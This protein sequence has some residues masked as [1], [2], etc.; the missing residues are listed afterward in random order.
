MEDKLDVFNLRHVV[1]SEYWGSISLQ[2]VWS[3]FCFVSPT[4]ISILINKNEQQGCKKTCRLNMEGRER[5]N[6]SG[7]S[8][9]AR[10]IFFFFICDKEHLPS[11]SVWSRIV[12]LRGLSASVTPRTGGCCCGLPCRPAGCTGNGRSERCS[13]SSAVRSRTKA[14]TLSPPA[15]GCQRTGGPAC[16][17]AASSSACWRRT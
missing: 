9:S 12:L 7:T 10:L 17:W 2:N 5:G 14:P 11:V 15:L 8:Q 3:W 4:V 13:S 6:F 16:W 1:V